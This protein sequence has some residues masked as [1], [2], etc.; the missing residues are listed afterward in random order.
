MFKMPEK[1]L[2]WNFEKK[3]R[4]S[5]AMAVG[6]LFTRKAQLDAKSTSAVAASSFIVPHVQTLL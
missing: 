5:S 2:K 6:G 3:T 4:L 1:V